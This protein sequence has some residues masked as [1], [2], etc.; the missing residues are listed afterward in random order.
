MGI[1][2]L[3]QSLVAV[4]E[5]DFLTGEGARHWKLLIAKVVVH[6]ISVGCAVESSE[7]GCENDQEKEPKW[8]GY[9]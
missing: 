8:N 7:I 2:V 5:A 9:A 3:E 4:S 6:A 1:G